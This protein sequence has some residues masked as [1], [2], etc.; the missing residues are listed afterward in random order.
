VGAPKL[1]KHRTVRIERFA[2]D[3]VGDSSWFAAELQLDGKLFRTLQLIDASG[4]VMVATFAPVKSLASGGIAPAIPSP[5]TGPTP[6]ADF[7][8]SP[9]QASKAAYNGTAVF[10][11]EP[12]E[13]A[14]G[15][16]EYAPS[17]LAGWG[18]L[19]LARDPAVREVHAAGYGYA[20]ATVTLAK[21][22]MI[23]LV[24]GAPKAGGWKLEAVHYLGL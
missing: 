12:G 4:H 22:R 3:Q 24:I 8:A 9:T 2:T 15:G 16:A 1:A 7:A 20:I 18:K 17:L 6:L 11:T 10:G 14:V 21:S 5:T 13:H 19:A 23:V